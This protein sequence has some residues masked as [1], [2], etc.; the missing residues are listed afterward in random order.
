MTEKTRIAIL[1]GGI[2]AL[3]AA[4]ELIEQDS[5]ERFDITIY[6]LG[7]RLGG[8]ASVGRDETRNWRGLEHG[9][10]VWAGFYDNAFDLV[11]RLYARLNRPA[12]EWRS[13]FEGLNHFTVME[14][15]DCAWKPWVLQAR[16]NA[17]DPGIGL[18]DLAPTTL[19]KNLLSWAEQAFLDSV[20]GSSE[21]PNVRRQIQQDTMDVLGTREVFPTP[22]SAI[23]VLLDRPTSAINT[24]SCDVKQLVAGFR[25]QLGSARTAMHGKDAALGQAKDDEAR[26]LQILFDLAAGLIQ[27]LL[28]EEVLRDGLD[29]I[30]HLEWSCWMEKNGCA[31]ESLN[32]GVVRGC[33]DYVFGS[34]KGVCEVGA[35]VGTVGLLRLLLTYRGSIFYT[36]REPMGDFLFVPLYKYLR[37][38]GVKF[39][40]FHKL[41]KLVLST[42]ESAIQSIELRRQVELQNPEC[43]Y[44]PLIK[45]QE[46]GLESWPCHPLYKQID[47][48]GTL[49][50]YDLESFWTKWKDAGSLTL[51]RRPAPGTP[52]DET[53]DIAILATGFGGLEKTACDLSTGYP[54]TWGKCLANIKTIP[55]LA[56][57]LWLKKDTAQLGWADPRTVMVGF[58]PDSEGPGSTPLNSWQDN[59]P[60][61]ANETGQGA[62]A[63]RSLGYFVGVFP[64]DGSSTG[65]SYPNSELARAKSLIIKWM[66]KDL[67]E[68][69]P[70]CRDPNLPK[71]DWDLLVVPASVQ[72]QG[73]ARLDSQYIRPNINPWERY[74][75]SKPGTLQWRLWP[76][77]SGI[78]NLFLAGDWTR[79]GLDSGCIEAAVMSGRVAARAITGASMNIPGYGN[80]RKIPVPITLLPFVNLLKRL[81][82]RAAGGVGT[83]E[84]YCITIWRDTKLVQTLLPPNLSLAPPRGIVT[85]DPKKDQHPI[86]FLFCR[87]KNVRPGFVPIGGVNYHEIIELVPFVK[88]KDADDP[89][90]G[91]F[92]YM[93]HL[94]LDELAPVLIGV[95]LYGYNKR[96]ARIASAGGAFELNCDLGEISTDLSAKGLPGRA[97]TARFSRLKLVRQMLEHPLISQTTN[98]IFVYSHLDFFF[99][100]ATFQGVHGE[101][102]ILP[103]FDPDPADALGTSKVKS[104][105]DEEYGAFRFETNWSLSVPLSAGDEQSNVVPPDLQ[106]FASKLLSIYKP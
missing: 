37:D 95:N 21:E 25:R 57:Q 10:H 2:G 78:S 42:D 46:T 5:D 89:S 6:T 33:Y 84:G 90:G 81:K 92:S 82:T 105:L 52:I 86:V 79:T 39:K 56:L 60:L 15:V 16:P 1:G 23:A 50:R 91:P 87:Q 76:D 80:Y 48:D 18:L 99:D 75:L 51:Q 26:R 41:E 70:K 103:P 66:N 77:R 104:I 97:G 9:L 88:R 83:M 69:W 45:N 98:G 31:C 28:S 67:P 55:T 62:H 22:L 43:D 64:E 36:L 53:F 34:V 85:P 17:F 96:L 72:Q 63:S 20:L 14:Y 47:D 3:T 65:P 24:I 7:W 106:E 68:I 29:A 102:A 59:S 73:E 94:F 40:F 44:E 35:G 12:G 13:K 49:K 71:F 8:K 74:V 32:S 27:G 93:P 58:E 100:T 54:D 4:F 30:D 19:V 61:L 11:Q 38:K 101:V